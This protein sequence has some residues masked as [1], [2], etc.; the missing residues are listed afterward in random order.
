MTLHPALRAELL[1]DELG[2]ARANPSQNAISTGSSTEDRIAP[3]REP[4]HKSTPTP[5]SSRLISA[6]RHNSTAK[7]SGANH[8]N[9]GPW[10]IRKRPT[11][12]VRRPFLSRYC[13]QGTAGPLN[14]ALTSQ[15]RTA[16]PLWS[17]AYP[18][19]MDTGG[20]RVTSRTDVSR[21]PASAHQARYELSSCTPPALVRVK[22]PTP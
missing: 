18:I 7:S 13:A 3:G 19:T 21:N 14:P 12:D 15:M 22:R 6:N 10:H 11:K 4:F 2:V 5:D 16:H 9:A 8:A 1:D 17:H 20:V